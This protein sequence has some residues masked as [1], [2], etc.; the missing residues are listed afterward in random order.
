MKRLIASTI[1]PTLNQSRPSFG[2]STKPLNV[3]NMSLEA[4]IQAN[5]EAVN[6]LFS[7]LA[8]AI[9]SP[10]LASA[11]IQ[12]ATPSPAP[13]QQETV[14]PEKVKKSPA[15]AKS[16]PDPEPETETEEVVVT[17]KELQTK[18]KKLIDEGRQDEFKAIIQE[19]GG[20]A[21]SKADPSVYPSINAALDA[22]L[23]NS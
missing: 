17:L 7:L 2:Q 23:A 20:V 21:M 6:R 13:A 5:T 8:N 16:A 3:T 1:S 18:A 14:K 11:P 19:S 4:A 10:A 15:P 9:P 22:A 12:S